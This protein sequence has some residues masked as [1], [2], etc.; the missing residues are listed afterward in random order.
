MSPCDIVLVEGFKTDRHPKLEVF[1]K[2]TQKTPLY[3]QDD[4][5]VAVASDQSLS[6]ATIP[7]VDLNNVTAVADLVCARAESLDSVLAT[8]GGVTTI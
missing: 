4:R 8:L 7:V 1:R 2:E 3:P 6:D 5:I